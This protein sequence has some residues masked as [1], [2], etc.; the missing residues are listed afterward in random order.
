[1]VKIDYLWH[2]EFIVHIENANNEMVTILSDSWLSDYAVWDLMGRN[3]T[4]SLN[5]ELLWDIDAIFLSHAHMDHVDP[6]TLIPL[7]KNLKN[8]PT[9]LL[10]E[11]LL[12]IKPL[13]I[14]YLDNPKIIVLKSKEQ[15]TF[16]WIKIR[17]YVFETDYTTNEDDVMSL[18]ISN[19][20]EIVFTEVDMTPPDIDEVHNYLFTVFTERKYE[21]VV[22]LATRNEL[23]WNLK[24]LDLK[25]PAERKAFANDYRQNREE[26]IEYEYARFEEEMVEY[27]DIHTIRNFMKIFIGQWISYPK[28]VN[29]D[30]L[31]F[32]VMS[33]REN[34]EIEKGIS[35]E[36][37]KRMVIDMFEAWKSY[38][39][40]NAR[41]VKN[42][43]TSYLENF[44]L[45]K[46][47][48][49]LHFPLVRKYIQGPLRNE[50]R[51]ITSQKDVILNLL[52]TRFLPYRFALVE[53]NLK[54]AILESPS[55]SYVI[56]IKYGSMEKHEKVYYSYDF[57]RTGF[58]IVP[59]KNASYNESYWANDI[60]DFYQW[61]QELY[62]NFLH[63][64][65]E[66][67]AYRLWTAIWA[68]FINNDLVYKKFEHHFE[69][70]SKWE[71][72][73][74]FVLPFYDTL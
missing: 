45:A 11:T 10:P 42:E 12:I 34:V 37:W 1:M 49:D 73:K 64:L 6:Y 19:D 46:V 61:K 15:I 70:A 30:F 36:F 62:S 28:D 65:E 2:S 66:D 43:T 24:L 52:N 53:D 69:R 7:F 23:E 71:T 5:Y 74:S 67:K 22:Y 59:I 38:T 27:K 33:L 58:E 20:K 4:F 13:L 29:K 47:S 21:S 26:E 9:I 55:K 72:A 32:Q 50:E 56:E 39:I 68:C 16:K 40:Q 25:T 3:P 51:S 31:K 8:K 63:N 57:S 60:D 44:N 35:S 48:P 14:K 17:G 18:F 41:I 54:H